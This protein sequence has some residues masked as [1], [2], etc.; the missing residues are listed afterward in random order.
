MKPSYTWPRLYRS[1]FGRAVNTIYARELR[2]T[3]SSA[4]VIFFCFMFGGWGW[5]YA[6]YGLDE[7]LQVFLRSRFAREEEEVRVTNCSCVSVR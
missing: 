5:K 3:V 7:G 6:I 4:L 1:V 2:G